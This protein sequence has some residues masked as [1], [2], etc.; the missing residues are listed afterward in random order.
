LRGSRGRFSRPYGTHAV[1]PLF[2]G[3]EAPGYF[4]MPLRGMTPASP[5]S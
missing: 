5:V 4:R 1:F 3:A 2:P